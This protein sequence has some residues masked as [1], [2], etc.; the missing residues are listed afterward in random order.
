MAGAVGIAFPLLA[1]AGYDPGA[2][3]RTETGLV[4]L[5]LLYAGLP[6]L[7]K[8]LA[9]TLVWRFPIDREAAAATG[10]SLAAQSVR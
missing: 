5:G 6:V 9:V 2:N 8:L 10:A 4:A 1:F 7:L 3:I